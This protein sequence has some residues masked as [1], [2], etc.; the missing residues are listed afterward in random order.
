M[1]L[2]EGE[3]AG[4]RGFSDRATSFAEAPSFAKATEGETA[5][6]ERGVRVDGC[7]RVIRQIGA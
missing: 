5:G 4:A 3:G 7:W 6:K 1:I 2:G